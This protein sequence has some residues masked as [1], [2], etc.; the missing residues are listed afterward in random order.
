MGEEDNVRKGVEVGEKSYVGEQHSLRKNRGHVASTH[1]TES[2][3][4]LQDE[5]CIEWTAVKAH[6]HRPSH[7]TSQQPSDVQRSPHSQVR[8]LG[9]GTRPQPQTLQ[10]AELEGKRQTQVQIPHSLFKTHCLK[11]SFPPPCGT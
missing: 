11:I 10:E 4:V 9:C 3:G 2:L 5:E 1:T 7:W 8:T 6:P